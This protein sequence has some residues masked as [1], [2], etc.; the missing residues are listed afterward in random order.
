[1]NHEVIDGQPMLRIPECKVSFGHCG[2]SFL[3]PVMYTIA[4]KKRVRML[5]SVF[6]DLIHLGRVFFI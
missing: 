1:M 5:G 2:K 4:S 3:S 6:Q